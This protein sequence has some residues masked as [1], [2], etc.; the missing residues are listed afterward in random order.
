MLDIMNMIVSPL[1]PGF[2]P[3]EGIA[4]LLFVGRCAAALGSLFVE[5]GGTQEV[6]DRV[7]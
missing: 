2:T 3:N 1:F 6:R 7:V 4:K 5:R